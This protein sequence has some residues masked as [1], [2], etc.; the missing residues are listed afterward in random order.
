MD[1][2]AAAEEEQ[3]S[4]QGGKT[5][6][7]NTFPSNLTNRRPLVFLFREGRYRVNSLSL[8][9]TRPVGLLS[10]QSHLIVSDMRW[11]NLTDPPQPLLQLRKRMARQSN[12]AFL[13]SL[14]LIQHLFPHYHNWRHYFSCLV[15]INSITPRYLH[16]RVIPPA[17][18]FW[19]TCYAFTPPI[20]C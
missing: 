12:E 8:S 11:R 9:V 6:T 15:F 4:T 19:A 20:R 2:L 14:V 7:L 10:S 1:Q 5:K 16:T 3:R 13:D 18:G 17:T